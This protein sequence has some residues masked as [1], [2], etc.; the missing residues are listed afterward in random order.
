MR[1]PKGHLLSLH[2]SQF[3]QLILAASCSPYP[4]LPYISPLC[5][6]SCPS[7]YLPVGSHPFNVLTA[8]EVSS[9]G[10]RK[11]LNKKQCAFIYLDIYYLASS[12]FFCLCISTNISQKH[13]SLPHKTKP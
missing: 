5:L 3:L 1:L 8:L 9:V 6:S 7:I 4:L 2:P 11:P 10:T 13:S 12:L